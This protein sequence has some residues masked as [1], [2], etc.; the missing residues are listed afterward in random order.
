MFLCLFFLFAIKLSFAQ[1]LEYVENKGQWDSKIK[2]KSD[3]GGSV[4]FL[5]TNGYKVLLNNKQDL[6][7]IAALYSGHF[8]RNEAGGGI[9]HT[10]QPPGKEPAILHS[11]AYEVNFVGSSPNAR[12]RPDK[13][14][15]TYNN[16]FVGNDP[17]KWAANCKIYNAI[18]YEDI[19]PGID[20]RYYT[21]NGNLKYD[22]IV[23]PGADVNKIALRFDGVDHL[24]VKN[25]N[26][27][28]K[29]SL[30]EVSEMRPYSYQVDAKAKIDIDADY[31]VEGNTVRF[32]INN[33]KSTATLIIDPTLIFASFTGSLVDNWGYTATYDG[34]GNFYGGG[35]A[36]GTGYPV[37]VGAFQTV[38]GGGPTEGGLSGYDI[39]I[40]K[41]S[42]NGVTRLYG[43]YLG[44]NGSEQPHSLV[45]DKEGNLIIAGRTNSTDFPNLN[46]TFGSGG[47]FDIFLT[48]LSEDGTTL[49]GSRKIGGSAD[50]GVNIRDKETIIGPTSITRNYGDDAR[51]EVIV[52]N[53]NN[54]YLA[55]CTQSAD[56]QVTGSAFQP[57]FAGA[58]DGVVIKTNSDLSNILFSS[59][60]GGS[61]DDA[62]FVLS[63]NPANNNIY[64]GGATTSSDLEGTGGNAGPILFSSFRSGVSDGFVSIISND[65]VSLIKTV[66]VGTAGNDML[67]GVQ[68]DKFG[69]PYV[70]GTTTVALPV[71]NAAFNSQ[72]NGKQFITKMTADL[73]E[74]IYSANFGKGLSVPDISPTAFLVDRCENVYV[75]GWGGGLDI[76]QGYPNANTSGLST[77]PNAIRATSDGSDFYFFVLEK[78]ALSQLYGT[79]YGN[80]DTGPDVG[81]HVDGG[82]S[83]FDKEGVIYEAMCANCLQVG[84]F[85]TTPG[86][87]AP[88][89]LAQ[90]SAKCNEA[91]VKI[92]FELAG[93]GSGVQS[94]INGIKRDTSGCLPLTV[95]FTDTIATG[96][97]FV[98]HFNDGSPD[99]TTTEPSV[100]HIFNTIGDFRVQLISIDSMT[101]NISDTSYTNI[102]VRGDKAE[103]GF[104]SLKLPPCDSLKYQFNNTSVAPSTKPFGSQ[105]FEWDF[106]DGTTL[107]SNLP[108]VTHNYP[109][110]GT[111]NIAL[112]LID[113]SYCN[114]PD[115][116]TQQLR[117]ASNVE[118]QFE[119]PPFGCVPFTA[120]FTNTSLA[121]QQFFWD[122]GDGTSSTDENPVHVYNSIDTYTIKLR[123]I[124]TSTC[125]VTD[126]TAQTISV[127]DKPTAGFNFSPVAPQE[128]IPFTF[129]NLSFGA[130]NYKWIFGDGDT[131][132]TVSRDIVTSHFYNSSGIYNVCLVTYND[133]GC[134]DTACQ[135]VEA[136]VIPVVD[137]PS[138]FTPNNDGVNDF[139]SVKGFGIQ[140]MEWRIYNRWGQLVF[141]GNNPEQGWDGRYKGAIQPQEV[142]VYVL[143]A[144]FSD[145]TKYRKKGDI[146]LLR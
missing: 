104:T 17:T 31:L 129:T 12:V 2:F 22:L 6:E 84:I 41:L 16:Y 13:P 93:V 113:T 43:T 111:Y 39:G 118:A 131:L 124:D 38:Y 123:V 59:F 146:T 82:T 117:I 128:N 20:A 60:F 80:L 76:S 53:N 44:G 3:I 103:V 55:S 23:H 45:V 69:I 115:S 127:S 87:W 136:I 36:F 71:I 126:S 64:I 99:T 28:I 139:V 140:T 144:T 73:S 1:T 145:G 100:T 112:R 142:Y 63:L 10:E 62:A 47:K 77:T 81:D 37:S 95:D 75:A 30:G 108:S 48:K 121:G 134:T 56:F 58:Q 5:Q 66:Y 32:K 98:W 78:N 4:F 27:I 25:G 21:D 15:N 79:F 11:F 91:L 101:C 26:L 119:V 18:V 70:T 83:R 52:D 85:P 107:I 42:S 74:V 86:V 29:T 50:D 7:N 68:F 110:P 88:D 51:S 102:R 67:Y 97:I 89:N 116:A 106:G 19:Y 49:I 72:A 137:V 94:A 122:F 130:S 34:S 14:L 135:Q 120:I 9:K 114:S 57:T 105:S 92:A 133:F 61:G 90:T 33:Y 40:I 46:G 65:G 141:Q 125:N 8:H 35:I 109:A 132:V 96:K 54:I 143:D 138:A 24:S